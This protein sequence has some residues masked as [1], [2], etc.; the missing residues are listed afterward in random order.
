MLVSGLY[1]G[2]GGF[3]LGL[4]QA[5]HR[6]IL[7]CENDPRASRVLRKRFPEL[8]LCLDVETLD[9][10]PCKTEIVTAGFPCQ[11]LSMAGDKTGLKG[12]KSS[13]VNSLFRLLDRHAAPWV[14]IE[15]VYFM[16]HL[17]QGMAIGSILDRLE[18][19]GYS[20][21]FGLAQR[22]RRVF[23][24]ASQSGDPRGV[25][26]VGDASDIVWPDVDM[27]LPIGFYWTE[28]RSGNGLT[29]N[30]I[31]PLKPGSALGIPSPPAVLLPSGRVVTPTIE[32]AERVQG[33]PQRWTSVLR[34]RK[35][36]R[37]R[38]RLVGNAVTVPVAEWIG[39]RLS[40]PGE[41][42]PGEDVSLDPEEPWPEHGGR[43]DVSNRVRVPAS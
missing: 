42:D 27:K 31:P 4:Q 41:Y 3:E 20:R 6:A 40:D 9:E 43:Q 39:H 13:I 15:N 7:L 23:I 8:P 10:L 36:R 1:S 32:A 34:D 2:I 19:L 33:F 16:L 12:S 5:G 18:E 29:G 21:A 38:W 28:G 22:R 11:N 14:V 37:H 26:L 35:A 17:A 24:V 30:A 25:L